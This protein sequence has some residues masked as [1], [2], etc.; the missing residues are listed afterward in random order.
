MPNL[1]KPWHVADNNNNNTRFI[2]YNQQLEQLKQK[3][4][5]QQKSEFVAANF[6]GEEYERNE[7]TFDEG[8]FNEGTFSEGVFIEGLQPEVVVVRTPEEIL[9][10]AEDE[11]Q[12]ILMEAKLQSEKLLQ[13][14]RRHSEQLKM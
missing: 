11:A 3:M 7:D 6:R 2:D 13:D 4:A 1:I 12:R 9:A 8:A 14:A 5:V 10:D